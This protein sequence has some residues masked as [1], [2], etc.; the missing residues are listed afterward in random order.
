MILPFGMFL[1]E[2]LF[3]H[4]FFNPHL[5]YQFDHCISSSPI[6]EYRWNV[7]EWSECSRTCGGG[8]RTRNVTCLNVSIPINSRYNSERDRIVETEAEDNMCVMFERAGERPT[9]QELC[10]TQRCPFWQ[11]SKYSMVRM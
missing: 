1:V 3:C 5:K 8:I 6:T 7:S 10:E 11:T 4:C 9:E 2:C